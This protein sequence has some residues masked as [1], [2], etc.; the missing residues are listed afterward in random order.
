M[1]TYLL[2]LI[3]ALALSVARA[4]VPEGVYSY[5]ISAETGPA[6]WNLAGTELFD[7]LLVTVDRQDG[8]GRLWADNSIVGQVWGNSIT[9]RVK[10]R[11]SD[12]WWDQLYFPFGGI[13][14]FQTACLDLGLDSTSLSLTGAQVL[15]E[16]EVEIKL[17]RKRIISS[18][19]DST[20]VSFPLTEGNDGSWNLELDLTP[21]GNY[22]RGT[23]TITFANGETQQFRVNGK[24]Y[25]SIDKTK[26]L[27]TS[28]SWIDRGSI[29][30]VA[31]SGPTLDIE[32]LK[33]KVSGQKVVF[34]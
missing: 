1:K 27:L 16:C 10:A 28:S 11:V 8:W 31:L 7:P 2:S 24:Y 6:L 3:S 20:D 23:A 33:G 32:S 18:T 5:D 34:P 22:L 14:I 21:F 30:W 9:N 26:L 4:Q 25:S 15:R 17:F 13:A 29:L 19:T 12:S